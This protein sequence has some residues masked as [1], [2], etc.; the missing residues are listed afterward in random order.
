MKFAQT[1]TAARCSTEC[2][3]C[4]R[5]KAS[6]AQ[7]L[8]GLPCALALPRP[9]QVCVWA[10]CPRQAEEVGIQRLV[11][12]LRRQRGSDKH[13]QCVHPTVSNTPARQL[14]APAASAAQ[15]YPRRC[16]THACCARPPTC[17]SLR[18]A[19]EYMRLVETHRGPLQQ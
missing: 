15:S 10:L 16:L 1:V 2:G 9:H 17:V 11:Q 7:H 6:P 19:H 5:H 13:P 12:H 14:C 18:C 3:A 8:P 4:L